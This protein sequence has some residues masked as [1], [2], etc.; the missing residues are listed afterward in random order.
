M[1][2]GN[3]CSC[4][5]A[6]VDELVTAPRRNGSPQPVCVPCRDL[7]VEGKGW[8]EVRA[9]VRPPPRKEAPLNGH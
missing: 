1:E 9:S 2:A 8:D 5:E 6:E 3:V 7:I 4:C